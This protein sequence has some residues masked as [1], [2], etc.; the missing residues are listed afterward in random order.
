MTSTRFGSNCPKMPSTHFGSNCPS[1]VNVACYTKLSIA[2]GASSIVNN[3][4]EPHLDFGPLVPKKKE[5]RSP[6]SN[7][8]SLIVVGHVDLAFNAQISKFWQCG[9]SQVVTPPR[10]AW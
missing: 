9:N 2:M 7:E 3:K 10:S 8:A 1:R 4:K 6:I 5:K